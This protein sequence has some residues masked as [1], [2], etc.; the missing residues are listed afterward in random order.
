MKT[1]PKN[2]LNNEINKNK[3]LTKNSVRKI[4][5]KTLLITIKKLKAVK[6]QNKKRHQLEARNSKE[7]KKDIQLFEAPG[8]TLKSLFKVQVNSKG[9]GPKLKE[10]KHEKKKIDWK[11]FSV[12]QIAINSEVKNGHE[13]VLKSRVNIR[14]PTIMR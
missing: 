3:K 5:L 2:G 13:K 1:D 6:K 14:R 9:Q 7:E 8:F 12:P 10:T 11:K 4:L